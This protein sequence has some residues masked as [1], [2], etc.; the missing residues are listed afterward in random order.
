MILPI[1]AYGHSTLRKVCSPIEPDY[2]DLDQL[3]SNMFETMYSSHGVGLAAPQVNVSIR[4]IVIDA[5]VYAEEYPE[6][7]GFKRVFINP[8]I[9]EESGSEWEFSE[10]CLSIPG[11]TEPVV[12]KPMVKLKY[13]DASFQSHEETFLG[14]V[15]RIIQHEYDHI[16]GV[17]FV[18]R[19]NSLRK[20][21]L[22][23]KLKDIT[24]GR[25]DAEYKMIFPSNKTKK[26]ISI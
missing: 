1:I 12:R 14:I 16:Q 9:L 8:Y 18:D 25:V 3:I 24:E 17:L 11:I 20:V 19:L 23:K 21:L 4:L 7:E 22:R 2:P 13:Q 15:A 5:S 6:A 10:G 26:K